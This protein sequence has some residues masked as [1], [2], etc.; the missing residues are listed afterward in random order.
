MAF[1][2]VAFALIGM[3]APAL[4]AEGGTG[5][6][7]AHD[8]G[9]SMFEV[10]LTPT[11]LVPTD[12]A[13]ADH[14]GKGGPLLDFGTVPPNPSLIRPNL[15]EADVGAAGASFSLPALSFAQQVFDRIETGLLWIDRMLLRGGA[16]D[17]L[18]LSEKRL[19]GAVLGLA[20]LTLV[21]GAVTL[22][23]FSGLASGLIIGFAALGGL[24]AW[25]H[26]FMKGAEMNPLAV[27]LGVFGGAVLGGLSAW[28]IGVVQST[29]GLLPVLARLGSFGSGLLSRLGA[30]G[31]AFWSRMMAFGSRLGA[32][33]AAFR[34]RLLG[35]AWALL[36]RAGSALGALWGLALQGLR[37]LAGAGG[38]LL[39]LALGLGQRAAVGF[40]ELVLR[41]AAAVR[42]GWTAIGGLAGLIRYAR[43]GA[44]WGL[45]QLG[46]GAAAFG[47]LVFGGIRKAP[48]FRWGL[49]AGLGLGAVH[50]VSKSGAPSEQEKEAKDRTG[51]VFNFL[52]GFYAHY[53]DFAEA[54]SRGVGK[55]IGKGYF[56]ILWP[57]I[58]SFWK[59]TNDIE[60]WKQDAFQ[61]VYDGADLA[62]NAKAVW[63]L[64]RRILSGKTVLSFLGRL[65]MRFNVVGG[66]I[67]TAFGVWD[68]SMDIRTMWN[69]PDDHRH[70]KERGEAAFDFFR[71][72][73]M[74]SLGVAGVVVGLVGLGILGTASLGIVPFLV[75]G[76][77]VAWAGFTAIKWIDRRWW[78][79]AASRW[80]GKKMREGVTWVK[81]LPGRAVEAWRA[82]R[83]AP[84]RVRDFVKRSV[85]K[86]AGEAGREA[87]KRAVHRLIKKIKD[88]R[89]PKPLIK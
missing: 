81:R 86:K 64:Q 53:F 47:R 8:D 80:V 73:G 21:I 17:G 43:G 67:S 20:A 68:M 77:L 5:S 38:R 88:L 28:L 58:P 54:D 76:G 10:E 55:A 60:K 33:G 18:S 62:L 30:L 9:A 49:L 83:E 19:L 74:T 39:R 51:W 63:D 59:V 44:K 61:D 6:R 57:L 65:A 7:T 35:W 14:T 32:L 3:G 12:E 23:P 71:H 84:G 70:D 66:I 78:N 42:A 16:F 82:V 15:P 79:G 25:A 72:M 40:A 1:V 24:S 56:N 31:V 34:S 85:L 36:G 13:Y 22:L 69:A 48:A 46:K 87:A 45:R 11:R 26:G 37:T 75:I 41:R 50:W 27:A 2:F 52:K 29:G 89:Y 4:V